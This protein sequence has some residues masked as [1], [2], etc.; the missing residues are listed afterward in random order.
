MLVLNA[1]TEALV[2]RGSE[3]VLAHGYACTSALL[4]KMSLHRLSS[5]ALLVKQPVH[6]MTL[7]WCA[8][9]HIVT[10]LKL[11]EKVRATCGTQCLLVMA[12]ML[13]CHVPCRTSSPSSTLVRAHKRE[14]FLL[15]FF[16]AACSTAYSAC[17]WGTS[18]Q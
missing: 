6:V 14:P 10:H 5:F 8:G 3:R 15:A 9:S 7:A 16:H 12:Y 11:V 18:A 17:L 4:C 13:R 1:L 2:W